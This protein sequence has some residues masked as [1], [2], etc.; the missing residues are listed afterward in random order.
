MLMAVV[1]FELEKSHGAR[2]HRIGH[3]NEREQHLGGSLAFWCRL[4]VRRAVM[5]VGVK[6]RLDVV[7]STGTSVSSGS[8]HPYI[9]GA[10][11]DAAD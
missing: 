4:P 7:H 9:V 10:M 1:D 6:E 11:F 5:V 3:R 2:L 8:A